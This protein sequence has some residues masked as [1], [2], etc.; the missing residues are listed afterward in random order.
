MKNQKTVIT[1]VKTVLFLTSPMLIGGLLNWLFIKQE[2]S[3]WIFT[4]QMAMFPS[5]IFIVSVLAS[6]L[7]TLAWIYKAFPSEKPC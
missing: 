3:T 7:F 4:E 6:L 5:P 1:I 2:F